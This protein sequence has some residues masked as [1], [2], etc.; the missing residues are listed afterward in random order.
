MSN[1]KFVG[2]DVH[3]A[4]TTYVVLNDRGKVVAQGVVE[5]TADGLLSLVKGISGKVH[6]TFEE[7]TQAA[8]LAT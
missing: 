2:F 5:T 7:S 1:D 3:A 4:T 6:L 8:W